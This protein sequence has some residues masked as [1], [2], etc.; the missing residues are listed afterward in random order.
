MITVMIIFLHQSWPPAQPSDREQHWQQSSPLHLLPHHA[1]P[2]RQ[3]AWLVHQGGQPGGPGT[4]ECICLGTWYP[5]AC[6][7]ATIPRPPRY[8]HAYPQ[9]LTERAQRKAFLET[10]RWNWHLIKFLEVGNQVVGDEVQ[11]SKRERATGKVALVGDNS[12]QP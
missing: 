9:Y 11:D 10:R 5:I 8:H 7:R 12:H 3:L 4:P 6:A 2:G 1:L